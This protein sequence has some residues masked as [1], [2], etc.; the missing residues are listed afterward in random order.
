MVE[1]VEGPLLELVG[2]IEGVAGIEPRIA[3]RVAAVVLKVNS[4]PTD[5]PTSE[6]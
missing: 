5:F 6:Q 4:L 1:R 2:G 3:E